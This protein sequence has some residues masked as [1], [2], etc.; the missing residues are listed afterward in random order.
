M[1]SGGKVEFCTRLIGDLN[2]LAVL[3]H[4]AEATKQQIVSVASRFY[5]PLGLISPVTIQFKMLFRDLCLSKV[6]WD[7][8]LS[9]E[10]LSK[11]N[12]IASSFDS[13]TLTIP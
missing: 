5:D 6:G 7:E 12:A 13:V 4:S 1:H 3:V 8:P 10:L 11:W 9:G 2:E